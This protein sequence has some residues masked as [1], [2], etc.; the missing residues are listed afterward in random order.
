MVDLCTRTDA[1]FHDSSYYYAI[2]YGIEH[3][4][5]EPSQTVRATNLCPRPPNNND[6]QL[7]D[8]AVGKGLVSLLDNQ[9]TKYPHSEIAFSMIKWSELGVLDQHKFITISKT[10]M[11]G[12]CAKCFSPWPLGLMCSYCRGP[13][14]TR[15]IMLYFVHSESAASVVI[16]SSAGP[17]QW[18][19]ERFKP[20]DPL[21]V[22]VSLL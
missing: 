7:T 15:S 2:C 3:Q 8:Y 14:Y 6:L 5:V 22:G 21:C 20:C 18:F 1:V 4:L 9:E 17:P 10:I 19:V 16:S 11:F 13:E 12:N